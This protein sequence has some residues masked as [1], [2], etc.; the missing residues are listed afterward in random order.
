VVNGGNVTNIVYEPHRSPSVRI[1]KDWDG[2]ERSKVKASVKNDTLFLTFPNVYKD[3][4]EKQWLLRNIPVRIFSSQL[5]SVKGIDTYLE[6]DKFNHNSLN[7]NL[8]GNSAFE[9]ETLN[10]SLDSI[11]IT[12]QDSSR[13]LFEMSPD[14][15]RDGMFKVHFI[16]VTLRDHSFLDLGHAQIDSLRLNVSDSS[17]IALSGG[18]MRNNRAHNFR[19]KKE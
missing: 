17:G 9:V 1:Y 18:T 11:Y 6:L 13:I 7:V 10:A 14:V 4:Y 15:R 19:Q 8:S 5:L 3:E 16:D 12:A 2:Y